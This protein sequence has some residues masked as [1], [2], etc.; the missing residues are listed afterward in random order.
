[1]AARPAEHGGGETGNTAGVPLE[2]VYVLSPE[3]A[4]GAD[5]CSQ[6]GPQARGGEQALDLSNAGPSAAATATTG[7][8]RL[9]QLQQQN[10][11]RKDTFDFEPASQDEFYNAVSPA[12]KHGTT[13]LKVSAKKV[14]RRL[15]RIKP[16]A[17]QLLWESKHAGIREC[18][19]AAESHF[20]SALLKP[21]PLD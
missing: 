19:V 2:T 12:L 4:V 5:T 20:P 18:F 16:E 17:G 9:Q 13:M 21:F 11:S 8:A 15:V 1:M 6:G 7:I 3:S 14:Q 10:A